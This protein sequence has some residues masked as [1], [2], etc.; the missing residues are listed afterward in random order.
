M[1]TGQDRSLQGVTRLCPNLRWLKPGHISRNHTGITRPWDRALLSA[2]PSRAA[3]VQA[4]EKAFEAWLSSLA[5]GP[6]FVL[7]EGAQ[8]PGS[9]QFAGRSRGP[10]ESSCPSTDLRCHVT[11]LGRVC[12]PP[13][14]LRR[15][16]SGSR[17]QKKDDSQGQGGGCTKETTDRERERPRSRQGHGHRFPDLGAAE[18]AMPPLPAS[19]LLAPGGHRLQQCQDE[20]HPCPD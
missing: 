14:V 6:P 7:R 15:P 20:T 16:G 5:W 17:H 10:Q 1:R 12:C 8:R 13:G 11:K 19:C 18:Q 2:S 3:R 9:G 4:G